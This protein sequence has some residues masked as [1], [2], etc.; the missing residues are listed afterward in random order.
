MDDDRKVLAKKMDAEFFTAGDSDDT[1]AA[2]SDA[3][4][5]LIQFV[6]S[7]PELAEPLLQMVR[8]LKKTG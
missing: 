4:Q 8:L 5:R 3:V 7:S 2:D 1:D 6:R